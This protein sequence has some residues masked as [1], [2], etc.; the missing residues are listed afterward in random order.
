[1]IVDNAERRG[2]GLVDDHEDVV[3]HA[4]QFPTV[5]LQEPA[6]LGVRGVGVTCKNIVMPTEGIIYRELHLLKQH[7]AGITTSKYRAAKLDASAKWHT[8]CGKIKPR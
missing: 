3:A 2:I 4:N 5:L 6:G 7:R 1:V 8:S